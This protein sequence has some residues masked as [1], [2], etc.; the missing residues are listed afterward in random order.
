MYCVQNITEDLYYVG[1]SDRRLQKF[2][3]LH[4]VPKGM[5]YN[6]YLLLDEKTVLFDT[7]DSSVSTRFFENID[8]VL[9]GRDLD[10]II[11]NHMEPDHSATLGELF[12][13]HPEVTVVANAKIITMM[14][15]F[16]DLTDQ[17]K[18]KEV[19]E[20][21]LFSTGK[22]EF[23]FYLAP[24]VHWPEVMVTYDKVAKILFS[25]DAFGTFGAIDGNIFADELDFK[26]EWLPEAR[27]YYSNIV[28]KYGPQTLKILE[29]VS[30]LELHYV[31]PLHGPIWRDEI[32]WY[33]DKYHKWASYMP[34]EQGVVVAYASVYGNTENAACI[35]A[36]EL[37]KEGIKNVKMFD[38]SKTDISYVLSECF[39]Y[40]HLVLA[41]TTYN[42]SLF[43]KMEELLLDITAHNLKN[44]T[45]AVIENGTWAPT[46]G[47]QMLSFLESMKNTKILS[48]L[49][50]VSS[51]VKEDS[52]EQIV[53]LAK[54]IASDFQIKEHK[55]RKDEI[56]APFS[57]EL[58][59]PIS[60][61]NL[62]YGLYVLSAQDGGKDNACIVNTVIQVTEQPLRVLVAVNKMNCTHDMIEKDKQ[63]TISIL[64]E[65]APFDI[66]KRFG[67]QSGKEVDKF[68]GFEDVARGENGTLYLNKY[69]N[70]FVS[71]KVVDEIDHGTHTVFVGEVTEAKILEKTPSI[72]YAYYHA[73]TKPKIQPVEK[74]ADGKKRWVCNVCGFIY[75]GDELPNDYIC[76]ICKHGVD[77][78]ELLED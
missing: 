1:A 19:K 14:N 47:K 77:V 20:G 17:I 69:S 15:R 57:E 62:S 34:E 74:K 22:H 78:F 61:F 46:S 67:F 54:E 66:F 36:N 76:P 12:I 52:R 9:N 44:R 59:N 6:S 51:A 45:V 65:E 8:F 28:G 18:I 5:S 38:L 26:G 29:K 13:R 4:D 73:N 23:I 35:M 49:A 33:V 40:S 16:F 41:S 53:N 7:V 39:R 63:F 55:I 43:P 48:T 64:T 70:A 56:I 71:A 21:D 31:C 60:L 24:M 58:V 32:L 25:A 42:G 75:E 27:R 30:V 72:T 68:E 3:A 50:T 2:E 37:A 10:Y 11:I